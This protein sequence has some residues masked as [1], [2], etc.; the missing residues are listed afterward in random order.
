MGGNVMRT[1]KKTFC[2]LR[3]AAGPVAGFP[4]RAGG[5]IKRLDPA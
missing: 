5:S 4:R 1:L 3:L 2:W